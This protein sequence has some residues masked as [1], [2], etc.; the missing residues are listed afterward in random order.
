LWNLRNGIEPVWVI[1]GNLGI[2]YELFYLL[3]LFFLVSTDDAFTNGDGL[4]GTGDARMAA[5]GE[6][7][8]P[9]AGKR[10]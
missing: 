5:H 8:L 7:S 6:V 1:W 4:L 2:G 10:D 3:L 9:R